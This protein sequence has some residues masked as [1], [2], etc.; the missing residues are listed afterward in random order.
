MEADTQARRTGSSLPKSSLPS[1]V[2]PLVSMEDSRGLAGLLLV[3]LACLAWRV[4]ESEKLSP[5]APGPRGNGKRGWGGF[6][7]TSGQKAAWEP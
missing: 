3:L 5:L 6:L 4:G 7:L 2:L 1:P